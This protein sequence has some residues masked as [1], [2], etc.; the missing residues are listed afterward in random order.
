MIKINNF[1]EFQ[2]LQNGQVAV[3]CD[4]VFLVPYLD[5]VTKMILRFGNWIVPSPSTEIRTYEETEL[6]E[7][8]ELVER[9]PVVVLVVC[10]KDGE[11]DC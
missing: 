1:K 6:N 7:E 2:Q 10:W 8:G 4:T 5:S 9:Q 3:D 11:D